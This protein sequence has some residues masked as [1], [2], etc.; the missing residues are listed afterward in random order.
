M[1][2]V[3]REDRQVQLVDRT[4]DRHAVAGRRGA[5]A[6]GGEAGR[7]LVAGEAAEARHPAGLSEVVEGDHGFQAL[8]DAGGDAT[9]VVVQG[10]NGYLTR[11]RL[12]PRPLDGEAVGAQAQAGDDSYVLGEAVI[13]VDSV[14]RR[15]GE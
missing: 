11:L 4:G 5:G 8:F 9:P 14:A 15:L 13:A 1:E 6:V 7:N 2:V 10:G 12:D 3:P